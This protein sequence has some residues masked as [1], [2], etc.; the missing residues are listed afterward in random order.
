MAQVEARRGGAA[1]TGPEIGVAGTGSGGGDVFAGL[2]EGVHGGQQHGVD[3]RQ[4]ASKPDFWT[5]RSAHGRNLTIRGGR[6]DVIM[7]P[8]NVVAEARAGEA[9][10]AEP[11]AGGV[12]PAA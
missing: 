4:W 3:A 12:R 11:P 7:P 5:G 2:D 9:G 10:A 1:G 6:S 8:S